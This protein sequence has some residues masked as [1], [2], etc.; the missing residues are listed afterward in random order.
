M[1]YRV[2]NVHLILLHAHRSGDLSV[3]SHLILLHAHRYGDLSVQSHLIL[4][5]AHGYGDISVQ[6]HLQDIITIYTQNL[7]LGEI[8]GWA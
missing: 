5:H 3:Q 6:S 1:D 2:F 4:L 8:L 7:D